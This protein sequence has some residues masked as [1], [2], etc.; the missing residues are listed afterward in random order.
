MKK[1]WNTY[2]SNYPYAMEYSWDFLIISVRKLSIDAGLDVKKPSVLKQLK[3][4]NKDNNKI[5]HNDIEKS[6]ELEI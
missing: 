6:N 3:E 5:K 4:F 2:K 1:Q